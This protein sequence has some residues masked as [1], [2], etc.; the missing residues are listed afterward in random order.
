[1]STL[2]ESQACHRGSIW[3]L[4]EVS[5][6][7]PP[8]CDTNVRVEVMLLVVYPSCAHWGSLVSRRHCVLSVDPRN[9]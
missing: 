1:M 5:H 9:D 3:P 2:Y 8:A 4:V 7:H 6:L